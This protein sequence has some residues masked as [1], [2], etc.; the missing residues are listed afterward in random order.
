[1]SWHCTLEC[2]R[3]LLVQLDSPQTSQVEPNGA[4]VGTRGAGLV[5]SCCC[6]V[7]RLVRVQQRPSLS[8]AWSVSGDVVM[9]HARARRALYPGRIPLL[10]SWE[11]LGT[12]RNQYRMQW[13]R[14]NETPSELIG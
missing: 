6:D 5:S 14:K 13:Y 8:P 12:S 7:I 10:G 4:Q 1:M 3:V 9:L 2:L 11:A